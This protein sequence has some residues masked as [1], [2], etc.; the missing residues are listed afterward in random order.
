MALDMFRIE[1]GLEI[2]ELV[3][4]LQGA[5]SPGTGDS[6][7]APVGSVYTDNLNGE[8]WT[9]ITVGTGIAHWSQLASQTWVSNSVAGAVSWREPVQVISTAT[10]LPSG[11]SSTVIDG[12][13]LANG[14]R[15]LFSSLTP[16]SPN[17]YVYDL[18]TQTFTV[19]T[20]T[21]SQGDT[22]Y[23]DAG[24]QGGT[25]WTWNGTAWVRFDTASVDELGFIRAYDGK[26]AAGALMPVYTSTTIVSQ[27]SN[28]TAAI[29]ALDL[30][31]GTAVSTGNFISHADSLSVNLQA[32]D[33][34]LG[35]NVTNGNY[36]LTAN[37]MNGNIQALDTAFGPATGTGHWITNAQHVNGN[38]SALDAEIGANV[39]NG[40]WVLAI[41]TVNQNIQAI[42]AHLG[43]AVTTG[44]YIINSDTTNQNVQ[45]LDTALGA[46][47]VNGN[48]VLASNKINT[49]IQAIDTEI[50]AQVSDGTYV[51]HTNSINQNIQV[52]D[53][54]LGTISKESTA[55]NVTTSTVI[56]TISATVVKWIVKVTDAANSANV[57]AY[58]VF[59]GT[60]GLAADWTKFATLKLGSTIPG[61]AL[62]VALSGANLQLSIAATA[63]VN[64]VVRR[65]SSI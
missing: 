41:N 2:D 9:K 16:A 12:V 29:S 38:L 10:T 52:I 28:L 8:I 17:V 23:V 3:Q 58:E 44:N 43:A 51:L 11:P 1:K 47:V 14:A 13:T 31:M 27:G 40:N 37:K 21:L 50:G 65:V 61:L 33:T 19:D 55:L 60:N 59:A 30:E 32:V 62:S 4:Y 22:L 25:R 48:F 26:P 63:N 64:V 24:T 56:D 18:A 34:E 49:N 46:N 15:V 35:A 57:T 36:I 53:T 39:S 45:L 6:G 7:A 54:A 5:G 20:N 42:D